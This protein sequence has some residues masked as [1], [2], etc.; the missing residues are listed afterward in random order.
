MRRSDARRDSP[1]A[2]R[3]NATVAVTIDGSVPMPKATMT[4]A[5]D[6]APA[7][8]AASSSIEYVMPQ[9]SQPQ[10]RPSPMAPPMPPERPCLPGPRRDPAPQ[11][12]ARRLE[13]VEEAPA[14]QQP[15]GRGEHDQ[16]GQH[17]KRERQRRDIHR[18]E[19]RAAEKPGD[20]ACDR[21]ARDPR[22]VVG[23]RECRGA[24]PC[25]HR[26][27]ASRARRRCRRTCRRSGRWRRVL[28]PAPRQ[29]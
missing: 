6:A 12:R 28:R 19:Q 21:V 3:S 9:G 16:P 18:L 2:I 14:E 11:S 22:E 23:E 17:A 15:A 10:A 27:C 4:A 24:P 7:V 25:C 5:P 8:V 26:G 20:G 1:R 29:G 13:R